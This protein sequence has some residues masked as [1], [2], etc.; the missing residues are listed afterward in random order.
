MDKT[1]S[2]V[3]GLLEPLY[4]AALGQAADWSAFLERLTAAME[5]D[6]GVLAL[7]GTREPSAEF[8]AQCGVSEGMQRQYAERFVAIDPWPQA[9]MNSGMPL[10][11]NGCSQDFVSMHDF[12]RSEYY[13]EFWKENGNLFHTCGG[14]FGVDDKHIGLLATARSRR[15]RAF[16]PRHALLMD[17]VSPH[18]GRA[19]QLRQRLAH[20]E[21]ARRT[22]AGALDA[23]G[24]PVILLDATGRILAANSAAD[25][26][27]ASGHAIAAC[28]GR[29]VSASTPD[30]A[31][32]QAAVRACAAAT[33]GATA[34]CPVPTALRTSRASIAITCFPLSM[35]RVEEACGLRTARVL[36]AITDPT[37]IMR[38]VAHLLRMLYGLTPTEALLAE[39]IAGGG[40]LDEIAERLRMSK[41][42]AR[43]HLRHVFLK[44]ET[45]RQAQLVALVHRVLPVPFLGGRSGS[46]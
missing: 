8:I 16:S 24:D 37:R 42:T 9:F 15:R 38:G 29:L 34:S 35:R 41:G 13:N 12:A 44:T 40:D 3:L 36:V 18:V 11:R 6:V 22:L 27:L 43:I 46:A 19:L 33:E 28:G 20:A 10:G 17:M 30:D 31:M 39:G 23:I 5:G 32:L 21:E 1:S 2:R 7:I 4:D 25:L 14:F 45:R 26:E